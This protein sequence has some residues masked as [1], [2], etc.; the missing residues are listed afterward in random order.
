M[1]IPA[2]ILAL[3][4]ALTGSGCGKAPDLSTLDTLTT[5]TPKAAAVT[6]TFLYGQ[7]TQVCNAL[8]AWD[9]AKTNIQFT[10]DAGGYQV[11]LFSATGVT[12]NGTPT[13]NVSISVGAAPFTCTV[14]VTDG[15]IASIQ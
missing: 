12:Q 9:P 7:F 14:L 8:K 13:P 6:Q 3:L 5:A 11:W 15:K 1:S 2:L 10:G 4:M